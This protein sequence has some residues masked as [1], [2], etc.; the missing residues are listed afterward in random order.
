EVARLVA[1]HE[2]RALQGAQQS[3]RST[4]REPGAARTGR[5]AQRRVGAN[6]GEQFERTLDRSGGRPRDTRHSS[7]LS[8]ELIS[9]AASWNAASVRRPSL[10]QGS[11]MGLGAVF[12]SLPR[13]VR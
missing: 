5:E 1:M 11:D 12:E 6:L 9:F 8:I 3:K 10:A 13:R 2:R 7:A 4:R